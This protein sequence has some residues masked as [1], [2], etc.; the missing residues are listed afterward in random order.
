MSVP[1]VASRLRHLLETQIQIQIKF[2]KQ[3][4]HI[5]RQLT[6]VGF[7]GLGLEATLHV[8]TAYTKVINEIFYFETHFFFTC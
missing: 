4:Q 1:A 3:N 6:V 5:K 7:I 2:L 8:Q